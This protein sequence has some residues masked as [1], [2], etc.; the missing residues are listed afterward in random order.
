MVAQ[1]MLVAATLLYTTIPPCISIAMHSHSGAALR[2]TRAI[3]T[4]MQIDYPQ[5][6][7]RRESIVAG[8][9]TANVLYG[10]LQRAAQLPTT[11][12]N[13]NPIAAVNDKGALSSVLWSSFAMASVPSG[14]WMDADRLLNMQTGKGSAAL[15]GGLYFCD[16]TENEPRGGG[17]KLPTLFGRAPEQ[18]DPLSV[19]ESAGD[20]LVHAFLLCDSQ[21]VSGYVQ[22]L[23]ALEVRPHT[24]SLRMPRGCFHGAWHGPHA[25]RASVCAQ[26]TTRAKDTYAGVCP[27]DDHCAV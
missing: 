18:S 20:E 26:R 23:E 6:R 5:R 24:R 14:M 3:A 13:A 12:L 11:E 21:A 8:G 15:R 2:S 27:C 17:L 25:C 16:M 19:I 10:K 4:R 7:E 22:A 1:Q 9:D